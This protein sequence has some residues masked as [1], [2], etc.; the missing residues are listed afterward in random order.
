MRKEATVFLYFCILAIASLTVGRSS[1]T[2]SLELVSR[3]AQPHF[4]IFGFVSASSKSGIDI[5]IEIGLDI[6]R[7]VSARMSL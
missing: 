4:H 1:P 5:E 7:E 2:S 3:Y 6:Q